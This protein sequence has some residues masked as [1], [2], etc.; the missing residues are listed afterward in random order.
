MIEQCRL[1]NGDAIMYAKYVYK[2]ARLQGI[3]AGGHQRRVH[4][5]LSAQNFNSR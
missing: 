1:R 5:D 4:I 2:F 3:K